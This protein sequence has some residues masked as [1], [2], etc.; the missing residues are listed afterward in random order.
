[1]CQKSAHLKIA[2]MRMG[3]QVEMDTVESIH[4]FLTYAANE[5]HKG[6]KIDELKFGMN[7]HRF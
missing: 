6:G 7:H 1:M 4:G 2:L 5:I 3:H